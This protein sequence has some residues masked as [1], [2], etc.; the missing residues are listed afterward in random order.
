M[1]SQ[2]NDNYESYN[3]EDKEKFDIYE[4]ISLSIIGICTLG[5]LILGYL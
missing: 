5:F 1:R 4:I 2:H 3:D